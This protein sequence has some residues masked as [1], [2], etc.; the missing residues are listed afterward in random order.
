MDVDVVFS[1]SFQTQ[2]EPADLGGSVIGCGRGT[3]NSWLRKQ[4]ANDKTQAHSCF[5]NTA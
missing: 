4:L 5:D 2:A 3:R 1:S